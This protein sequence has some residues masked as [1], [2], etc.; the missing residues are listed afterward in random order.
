M[1]PIKI[2]NVVRV[3]GASVDVLVTLPD[4]LVE[5]EGESLRLGQPGSYV[6]IPLD[7]YTLIGYVTHCGR[8]DVVTVDVEPERFLTVQLVGTIYNGRFIPGINRFPTLGD[9][10]WV[11]TRE[12]F[13]LIF[14]SFDQLLAGT[15]E[16]RSFRLGRFAMNPDQE[17]RI[18]GKPFFSRSVAVLGNS[19]SGKSCA[20]AKI[21]H[22]IVQLPEAQVILFD[23]HGEYAAAFSDDEGQPLP[24]V[25]VLNEN[26]FVMPYWLLRYDEL[27]NIFVDRTNVS[28]I[29]GQIGFLKEALRRLKGE[30]AAAL[31]IEKEFTI[32]TPIYF[33]LERLLNYARN[34]NEARFILGTDRYALASLAERNLSLA[35]QEKLLLER[36]CEFKQGNP[37]GEIPHP[38]YFGKLTPLINAIETR[39]AD[40]RYDFL[41]RPFEQARRSSCA[42][43]FLSCEGS[44]ADHS[45]VL[46][47]LLRFLCGRTQPRRNLTI[48][49]LSG[50]PAEIIDTTVAVISRLVFDFNFWTPVDQRQPVLL[51]FEEAHNY[52]PQ[53]SGTATFARQVVEKIAKE[54]R[55]YG[56]SAMVVSQRPSELSE[57]VLSQCANL[58]VMRITNP[59]DQRY[60]CKIASETFAEMLRELPMLRPGEAFVIGDAVLMPMRT[61]IDRPPR[62]PR[63]ADMDFFACWLQRPPD[64]AIPE[65]LEHWWRQDRSLL[66][67]NGGRTKPPQDRLQALRESGILLESG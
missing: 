27:E 57:T 13:E 44:A 39:L 38:L 16:V 25:T 62:E 31:G 21:L 53:K 63:S 15:R 24:N 48:V 5:V 47:G 52:I 51:V 58:I 49:D 19:G 10:V 32:D 17:V 34:M 2:G 65:I 4:L 14:G 23:L 11:A 9:D 33:D 56:V 40:R 1:R 59:D 66:N 12:D 46:A 7:E 61:V 6:T 42:G 50:L 18:L 45:R 29:S 55:K 41:L 30:T 60:V 54:G 26:D 43:E 37:E 22:E 35:E 3:H 67:V 8:S 36:R 64:A 28:L 20:T